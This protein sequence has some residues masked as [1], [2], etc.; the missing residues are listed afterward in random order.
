MMHALSFT[1]GIILLQQFQQLPDLF[2]LMPLVLSALFL[3]RLNSRVLV[4]FVLGFGWAFLS[5]QLNSQDHLDESLEGKDI[6][7]VG[8][9]ISIPEPFDFGTRFLFTV[10][11]VE[12]GV[13]AK[14]VPNKI[15][16]GW[17]QDYPE[18][19]V[20]QKWKLLVRL[21]KPHG[22][23]NPGGFDYEGW[24]FEKKIRATGYVRRSSENRLLGEEQGLFISFGRLR[25]QLGEQIDLA[26]AN[27]Q[28][29]G[30]VKALA[31]GSRKEITPEQWELF[32][33]T[34]T[35]HLVAI[36]GLHIGL[37]AGL[38]FFVVRWFVSLVGVT[39]FAPYQV[40]AFVSIFAAV[41]YAALADFALP[42]QRA[43]LMVLVVMLSVIWR[44][45]R[46]SLNILSVALVAVLIFDPFAVSSASFW[47]S[48]GAVS[49]IVYL[50]AGRVGREKSLLKKQKIHIILAIGLAPILLLF[51]QQFSVV[52]PLANL[53]AIPLVGLIVVPVVLL[54]LLFL[55]VAPSLGLLALEFASSC[56]DVLVFFLDLLAGLPVAD[57]V[58]AAPSGGV[59]FLAMVGVFVLF[60]PKGFPARWLAGLFFLPVVFVQQSVIE[61]GDFKATLLDVGQGLSVV[62]QTA[63]HLL[64]FDTGARFGKRF[65]IGAMVVV[66][67]V[68]SI[69]LSK[70]DKL[71]VSHGD[72]DHRGGA[73]AIVKQL[74]VDELLTSVP[75]E[76]SWTESS[77]CEEGQNW[78]W[79][80]VLFRFLNPL[81]VGGGS[82]N[83]RSCVLQVS[84]PAGKLLL[85]GDIEKETEKRLVKKYGQGLMSDVLVVPHH[86]SKSSSTVSF[87][88]AVNPVYALFPLGYRNRFNFPAEEV[89]M[90]YKNRS[91]RLF[92]TSSHGAIAVSFK[93][94]SRGPNVESFRVKA[95]HYWNR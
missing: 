80:G 75:E 64:L 1:L 18:L 51:F 89:V 68:R 88:D 63:E 26:L 86:G 38:I 60:A 3:F 33:K 46:S 77:R 37:V 69:G 62:V 53:V 72:L 12:A 21:K 50:S 35:S 27:S 57:W 9:V 23:L 94:Q 10:D 31:I 55:Y 91:V 49:L 6:Q 52:A 66:P 90:R 28:V 17:Y 44:R 2:W 73:R 56:L 78:Q 4:W 71:V 43:L 45:E 74:V 47:L 5:A 58:S 24:L 82:E 40:A 19:R 7:V 15:R 59:S 14:L 41:C 65:D 29:A 16:L 36:S 67:Y 30:V 61:K 83:N 87:I 22:M 11:S 76:L 25:Q 54:A 79:D 85:T 93:Q 70:V 8:S 32:R 48:F 13:D 42:T 84:S 92:D 81:K 39:R 95:S 34:G 20:G